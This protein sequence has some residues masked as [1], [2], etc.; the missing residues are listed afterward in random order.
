M[1]YLKLNNVIQDNIGLKSNQL[2]EKTIAKIIVDKILIIWI[3]F[4]EGID[5][6]NNFPLNRVC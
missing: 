3:Y 4:G 2:Y 6:K 1:I 5:L